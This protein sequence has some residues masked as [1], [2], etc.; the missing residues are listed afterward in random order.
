MNAVRRDEANYSF[1]KE[2]DGCEG[3]VWAGS[4]DKIVFV[5]L[6]FTAR[7]MSFQVLRHTLTLCGRRTANLIFFYILLKFAYE[8]FV[9]T[10]N[11]D[12]ETCSCP[13]CDC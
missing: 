1:S 3:V 8:S 4:D 10:M 13:G 11:V 2:W 6:S 5:D 9:L 12:K 7:R